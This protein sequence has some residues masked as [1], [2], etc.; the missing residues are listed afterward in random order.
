MLM[1]LKTKMKSQMDNSKKLKYQYLMRGLNSRQEIWFIQE[2]CICNRHKIWWET[3]SKITLIW[4]LKIK[5]ISMKNSANIYQKRMTK[6]I[7]DCNIVLIYIVN[8]KNNYS[9]ITR[10]FQVRSNSWWHILSSEIWLKL[11]SD[12]L[13]TETCDYHSHS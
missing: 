2:R 13:L 10:C 7:I 8:Y 6:K 9:T 3:F 4:Y 1:V 11:W 12:W 5:K